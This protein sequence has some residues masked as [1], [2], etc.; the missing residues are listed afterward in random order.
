MISYEDLDLRLSADGDGF[1]VSARRG[2]QSVSERFELDLAR[3][4]WDLCLLERRGPREIREKGSALFDALIRGGVRDLYHQ[5]RGGGGGDAGKGLRIRILIDP[6]EERL[7]PLLHLPWEILFDRSADA[8]GTLALD[9][10]RP[11]VRTI[12]S[13]EPT[14][15]PV[16]GALQRVLLASADPH[17]ELDLDQECAKVEEALKRIPINPDVR[18]HVTLT[19]LLQSIDGEPQVVHFMGHGYLD[20]ARREGVLVL[21]DDDG[22]GQYLLPASTLAGFFIGKSMPRLVVLSSCESGEPGGSH[23]FGPFASTAAALVAAGLPAVVAMQSDVRNR[24]AI[25]FTER[26]YDRIAADD[27]VEA[28]VAQA[29]VALKAG[30]AETLDWAVPVLFVRSDFRGLELRVASGNSK[31]PPRPAAP[32]PRQPRPPQ[33]AATNNGPVGVQILGDVERVSY[34]ERGKKR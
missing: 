25:R 31:P 33:R 9:Q 15:S 24:S 34:Y 17:G 12:D 18:R 10:R 19:R 1:V 6:R 26:L 14:L 7:R 22:S 3:S 2:S 5:G 16:P 13:N 30:S 27:P 20:P 23:C 21:E 8:S 4:S 32:G 29:R 11:V 28:A